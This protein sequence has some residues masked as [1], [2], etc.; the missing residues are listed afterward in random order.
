MIIVCLL[1]VFLVG[2][3]SNHVDASTQWHQ[4]DSKHD[5]PVDKTWDVTLNTPI[6]PQSVHKENVYVL[7]QHGEKVDSSFVVNGLRIMIHPP[8]N[9]YDY[10]ETYSL[11][12]KDLYSSN[13]VK[14][15]QRTQLD[16]TIEKETRFAGFPSTEKKLLEEYGEPEDKYSTM[17][18]EYWVYGTKDYQNYIHFGLKDGNVSSVFTT[19]PDRKVKGI[20]PTDQVST[21]KSKVTVDE[22]DEG[23]IYVKEPNQDGGGIIFSYYGIQGLDSVWGINITEI[24]TNEVENPP[25]IDIHNKSQSTILFHMMNAYRVQQGQSP[26]MLNQNTDDAAQYMA[27]YS[28]NQFTCNHLSG[29]GN[30]T[31]EDRLLKFNVSVEELENKKEL[32][33]CGSGSW[34]E[35]VKSMDHWVSNKEFRKHVLGDWTHAGTGSY[36][37]SHVIDFLEFNKQ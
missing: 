17:Y 30:E 19:S 8:E 11:Y 2:I 12:I 37:Y 20:S 16:F 22:Q 26:L 14:M 5:V 7:N 15:Q 13:G 3:I 29:D 28:S 35:P 36:L 27:E 23:N 1:G 10:N 4:L 18:Y 32:I 24:G 6:N 31:L 33:H 25:S 9:G 34:I 21:V